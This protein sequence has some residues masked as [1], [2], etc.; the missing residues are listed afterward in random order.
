MVDQKINKQNSICQNVKS[1]M[2]NGSMINNFINLDI[3]KVRKEKRKNNNN[4]ER[5]VL[6]GFAIDFETPA[7]LRPC[8]GSSSPNIMRTLLNFEYRLTSI[9][10]QRH[11]IC[12]VY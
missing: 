9:L 8:I 12:V 1:Y 5:L 4:K 2:H 10:I 7:H 11:H 3:S 6:S